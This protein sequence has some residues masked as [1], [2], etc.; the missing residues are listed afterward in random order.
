METYENMFPGM[1]FHSSA[2]CNHICS[3]LLENF[4]KNTIPVALNMSIVNYLGNNSVSIQ[5]LQ[6]VCA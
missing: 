5:F 6:T 3:T 2:I 1:F 4:W